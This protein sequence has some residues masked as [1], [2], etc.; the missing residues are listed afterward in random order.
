M[1]EFD[2]SIVKNPEIFEQNR[3]KAHSDH[4]FV[5]PQDD[6]NPD[7]VNGF[8]CS[9]NGIWKFCYARNYGL[10]PVDFYKESFDCRHFDEIHVPAHIQMEGY[11]VPAYVNTQYP[12]DGRDRIEPGEIPEH[13]NPTACYVKYF[14]IPES[15]KGKP[16]YICFEGAESALALWLNGSYIGYSEDSFTPSAFELTPFLKEGENK[17][18]AMVF[19]WSAGS[20][21]EDQDFFRFSGIFRD[22]YLYTVPAVHIEDMKVRTI[23]DDDYR[24]ATLSLDL[25]TTA[26]G[27]YLLE[28]WNEAEKI[29]SGEFALEENTHVELPVRAPRLWSAENPN[30]YELKITVYDEQGIEQEVIREQ[31]G[32][33]RFELKDH[34]MYLNGRRIVFKGV[35]RHEFCS[36]TGRV[37]PDEAIEK[38][39]ITMKRNNINAIRTSHYPNKTTLYRLC[40]RYGLYVIDETNLET[41]GSWDALLMG[42]IP[43]EKLVPGDRKE[44]LSLVLDRAKSMYERDKNHPCILIW[45]CGNES[46][47]GDD[48]YEMSKYFHKADPDRLVHYEGVTHDPF[49]IVK[50]YDTTDITSVMY[51]P[52]TKVKEYL[53]THRDKPFI[54]CEYSHSMGN[55]TGAL[56][57]Y[58]E[59]AYE[60]ELYQGGFIWDFIDQSLTLTDRYGND[61]EGYGGDFGDRPCDYSFSGDGIVY[62]GKARE[63]SPKM[64]EVK[65]CYQDLFAEVHEDSFVVRN[66]SLFTDLSAYDTVITVEKEGRILKKEKTV[67]ALTP[68]SEGTFD[69]PFVIPE[70]RCGEEYVVTVSFILREDSLWASAG[71]EVAYG[72][73][74]IGQYRAPEPAKKKLTVVSGVH[75]IGVRSDDFEI[76]F[77]RIFGGMVSYRYGGRELLKTIPKPNFWRAMTE[78]DTA[79]LLPFR[80]GQWKAASIWPT[81]RAMYGTTETYCKVEKEEDHVTVSYRYILPTSPSLTCVLSYAVYGDGSVK[82]TL[83]LPPSAAAGELPEL[84]V[85]FG[86]D[87][88]FDQLK[89]YGLGP[90]ET[91][92]DRCHSKLGLYRNKVS[93]NLA[94]YLVPQEC[95]NKEQVR[96]AEVTDRKGQGL[97][98]T[99]DRPCGFSALPYSPHELDNAMHPTELPAPHY[100]FIRVGYQMGVGGDDT[101]G[102][103]T[104]PEYLLDNSKEL[105]VTFTFKGI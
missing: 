26:A 4:L 43:F 104:H 13:Y 48:I 51:I 91:Y 10:A 8:R 58:T 68:L 77:S 70:P 59:L 81:A 73:G 84:S 52:V 75:N 42:Q 72:Q 50:H 100:T 49:H 17:L 7:R 83:V 64:A 12:W 18:A 105:T 92:A 19:K 86:M 90:E 89:W 30:L 22:V 32:F 61:Y 53:E 54:E 74:V 3:L 93:D 27:K 33:R 60:D 2:Y 101:W 28:L 94:R 5:P 65:Y 85:L 103:R 66:R 41:H 57:K 63:P 40:D 39:L 37:L 67:I 87:A 78:N 14:E 79:N 21:C 15:F 1:Q 25:C 44:W 97:R 34:V 88:S 45:S 11:D 29:L 35:N 16:L 71:H 98:F 95:G 31:V 9:L 46:Y 55:S 80:A 69:Y 99:M 76:L 20:W 38:D 102:A 82:T 47:G 36:E 96:Y 24:D 56:H 62:G 6:G 23:L